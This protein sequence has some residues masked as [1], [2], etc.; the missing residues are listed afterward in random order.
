LTEV[1]MGF[2]CSQES[3]RPAPDLEQKAL[4]FTKH[5]KTPYWLF[6][7][8]LVFLLPRSS[9]G[10]PYGLS[11]RPVVGPFLNG[12]LPFA[13]PAI[14]GNW[15]TVPAF[16]SL[17]FTNALGITFVP[18][19]TNLVVW[20]R[21]GRV[22]S[23]ANVSNTTAKTLVLDIANRCQGWD[24][25]G[26]LGLAF[27]PGFVTN[28]YVFIYYTWVT[29]GTVVG[30]PT[31]RPAEFKT[32][33]Y[34]DRLSRFTLDANGVAVPNSEL[35]LV[36][37]TADSVWH[38]GGGLFF[39]PGNGFLYWTD[40]D[41]ERSPTQ[42]INQNLLSGV[43][44]IDV[45]Q[46]GGSV[47]HAI[48]KQPTNGKTANY[49]IPNDN[50]FVGRAGVLEEFYALGLRSP[51]R[52]TIDP[53]SGRIFIGDVG[54]GS[55]EEIDVI[56]SND[57]GGLNF[58]W[59][60]IEGLNGDLTQ[61]YIGVNKRPIID[62]GHDEGQAV[63]GGY[64]YRGAEFATD[65]GGRYIF[66]DNVQGKIWA[67][68]E[69][70]VPASKTLLCVLPKGPGSNSGADYT[71]L[72]SFGT[73]A[74]GELYL[75]QMGNLGGQI[76][77]LKRTGA[78]PNPA[79]DFPPLLS[80]TGAFADP[81]ALTPAD[82]LI[83]YAV[84]SAL[85]SDAAVKSRWMSIP[86]NTTISFTPT[87][88]W[89]FP[90]GSFWVKH[91]ELVTNETSALSARRRLET[92]LLVRDTNGTVFGA[93]YKWRPDNSDADLLTN[94]F[95]E[96]IVIQTAG[97]SRVQSWHYPSRSECLQCHT[98][99]AKGVLGVKTRQSN[100]NFAYANGVTDNQL[101]T[102]NHIGLFSPALNETDIA[103]YVKM[104]SVTNAAADLELR[105]RSYL[106]ANCAHCH[107]PGGVR[108]FWDARFETPLAS[109][110]IVNGSV[111]QT[112]GIAGAKVAV[113]GH[114]E[115]SILLRRAGSVD[116][117]IKMP[118]LAK[119]VVDDSAV[120]VLVD[121]VSSLTPVP[122]TIPSPW[123]HTD[124]GA[125]GSPGDANYVGGTLTASA[126]GDDIWGN[127][128]AF[129]YVYQSLTGDG[130]L[131]ARA[132]TLANTDAWAKAGVMVR[133]TLDAASRHAIIAVTPG[134]GTAF[135]RRAST[136]GGSDHTAGP[137]AAAPYWVRLVR[138]GST[139]TGYVSP[140]GTTW[141]KVDALTFAPVLPAQVFIGLALTAHNN[142]TVNTATLDNVRAAGAVAPLNAPPLVALTTPV[143]GSSFVSPGAI[144]LQASASD[145]DGSV[146]K[147][148]FFDGVTKLGE[149]KVSP[150]GL[151]WNNPDLGQHSLSARA[152]DN[153]GA[154]A[155]SAVVNVA[156]NQLALGVPAFVAGNGTV[157]FNFPGQNGTRYVVEAS[158]DLKLWNPI[159]TNAVVSGQVQ[160]ADPF[161][162]SD[163][164]FY[165]VRLWP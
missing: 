153:L 122:D 74:A 117:T 57:P 11:S 80:Q 121:W 88:E 120:A 156:V 75:C 15:S 91:F 60:R 105:A 79:R 3:N 76:F 132:N 29:P 61:P 102:W 149:S 92:R 34:H 135:Q 67:L 106:D 123:L 154:T 97:G 110:G 6:A 112:L 33:A 42:I 84:N 63:I 94:K 72:S 48:K 113:P 64:I 44:R 66:G 165:R 28:R 71:G 104:V 49:F 18:G 47:S 89:N 161:P 124:I 148:E 41:D 16:T 107:R 17:R 118:P 21:E 68:D 131:I 133:E 9:M 145:G 90:A 20:E 152:T 126:S 83:P 150:F 146:T 151:V 134:N 85:W 27:H 2:F 101:R 108:A 137:A 130:E 35:V 56:E 12:K 100:G 14:S 127:A 164:R 13:A 86:T 116:P 114:P 82:A 93:T 119:N 73:D 128:D 58:Q 162:A 25:S 109:A 95:D 81:A 36:D 5:M 31:V 96:D 115:K 111:S 136:G 8:M 54:A 32:G 22:W 55:R 99:A 62:Y 45:D 159:S 160:F 87:G 144:A 40:G 143:K 10:A 37:Q 24:D 129:H 138:A 52:M 26:L 157:Q 147:V 69:T 78:P 163:R 103:T 142:G 53:P 43:F 70:T 140:N 141:T 155:T 19:T 23:F 77:K 30:S 38:N 7:L 158:S 4:S 39:H 139:L 50:P 98:V 1:V 59:S 51:H 65:L 46:R 125:V